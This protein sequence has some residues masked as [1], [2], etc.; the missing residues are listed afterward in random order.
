MILNLTQH[1]GTPEQG[2]VEPS[3]EDKTKI[4]E[5]LT[6]E[7]IED[8]SQDA[9][10]DK[11]QAIADIAEKYFNNRQEDE[12]CSA[13]IG[14]ALYFMTWLEHSLAERYITPKYSFTQRVVE[15]R[16]DGNGGV[17]KT[18]VFKHMGWITPQV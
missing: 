10:F 9:M 17:V 16:Q 8:A 18:S 3:T 12:E 14:G 7:T 2:V 13:M 1:V 6:F 5:L 15:E 11:A 4:K